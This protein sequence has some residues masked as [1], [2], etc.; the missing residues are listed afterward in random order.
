MLTFSQGILDPATRPAFIDEIA[1][2]LGLTDPEKATLTATFNNI[3]PTAADDFA[4]FLATVATALGVLGASV[5]QVG[6]TPDVESVTGGQTAITRIDA[7]AHD[8]TGLILT[9]PAPIA[10]TYGTDTITAAVAPDAASLAS[11]KASLDGLAVLLSTAIAEINA[12]AAFLAGRVN[13]IADE[14]HASGLTAG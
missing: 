5:I 4:G 10:P 3:A 2:A 11:T 13:K 14:L 7:G 6:G 1:S 9:Y 12:N 8:T